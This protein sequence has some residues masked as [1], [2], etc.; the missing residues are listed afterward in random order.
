MAEKELGEWFYSTRKFP[1]NNP[2]VSFVWFLQSNNWLYVCAKYVSMR[3]F[4]LGNEKSTYIV[5]SA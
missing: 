2:A 4:I 5:V 1:V 3:F